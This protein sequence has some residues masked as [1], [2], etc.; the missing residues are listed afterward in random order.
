MQYASIG[1]LNLVV[2]LGDLINFC[3]KCKKID[4]TYFIK[5]TIPE[6]KS[7]SDIYKY[8]FNNALTCTLINATAMFG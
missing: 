5:R 2:R 1:F 8:G 3:C 6:K 7:E 4:R